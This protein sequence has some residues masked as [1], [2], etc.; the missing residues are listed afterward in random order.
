[1]GIDPHLAHG[2]LRITTGPET[3]VDDVDAALVAIRGVLPRL[4][5]LE[6]VHPKVVATA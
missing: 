4:R 5:S 3:T 2:S 6:G 1:M